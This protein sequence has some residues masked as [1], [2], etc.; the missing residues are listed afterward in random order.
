MNYNDDTGF[1]QHCSS[2]INLYRPPLVAWA[3]LALIWSDKAL[4]LLAWTQNENFFNGISSGE[5]A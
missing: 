3:E 5:E 1:V 2:R 4:T